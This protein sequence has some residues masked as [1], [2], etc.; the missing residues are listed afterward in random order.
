MR[1]KTTDKIFKYPT[2][3]SERIVVDEIIDIMDS[4]DNQPTVRL[5]RASRAKNSSPTD[6]GVGAW[7]DERE[8][9]M[10]AWQV[11]A[12][13]GLKSPRKLM[14]GDVFFIVDGSKLHR[15]YGNKDS[16]K[17]RK[18]LPR[19]VAAKKHLLRPTDESKEIART[20][21]KKE[22]YKLSAT[23]TTIDKKQLEKLMSVIDRKCENDLPSKNKKGGK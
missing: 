5:L 7:N 21:I 23:K 16:K 9:I 3:K 22:C 1:K 15:G 12:F 14:E 19:D 10:K 18:V 17:Y 13:V 20:E 6:F 11:E 8:S 4:K 2:S